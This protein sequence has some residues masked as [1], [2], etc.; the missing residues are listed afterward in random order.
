MG[1][2]QGLWSRGD[3]QP[4][5]AGRWLPGRALSVRPPAVWG[6]A[7]EAGS[8][9]GPSCPTGHSVKAPVPSPLL[10]LGPC[11]SHDYHPRATKSNGA[12]SSPQSLTF[13]APSRAPSHPFPGVYADLG[14]HRPPPC[15]NPSTCTNQPKKSYVKWGMGGRILGGLRCQDLL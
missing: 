13:S 4:A 15:R 11:G 5:S 7:Q 12:G 9:G 1:R 2:A 3:L 14:S 10:A 8:A 6:K